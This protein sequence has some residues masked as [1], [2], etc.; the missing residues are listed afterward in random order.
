M[1]PSVKTGC[2]KVMAMRL[3][4]TDGGKVPH[5][6]SLGDGGAEGS[7]AGMADMEKRILLLLPGTAPQ[8][9]VIYP[10]VQSY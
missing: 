1:L 2:H 5:I 4:I 6:H 10:I 9:L 7:K 8:F 3:V